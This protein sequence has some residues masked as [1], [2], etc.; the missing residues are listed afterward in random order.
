MCEDISKHPLYHYISTKAG[1]DPVKT[2]YLCAPE[3]AVRT[4]AGVAEFARQ[5]GWEQQAEDAGA[6][7]VAPVAPL[8]WAAEPDDLL[9]TLY[10]ETR[11]SFATCSGISIWGRSGSLWCWETMLYLV[12][13]HAGAD[14]AGR[15]LVRCPNVFAGTALVGGAPNNFAV[16]EQTSDHWLV[17][18]VGRNYNL[19]NQDIPTCL[20]M[21]GGEADATAKTTAHFAKALGATAE[22]ESTVGG[23]ACRSIQSKTTPAAEIRQFPGA[24]GAVPSLADLIMHQCFAHTI[25]WKNSPDGTLAPLQS[26]AE[27]YADARHVRR[28]VTVGAY[29][30]D[31]FIRLPKGRTAQEAQGLP[32][33]LTVHGRGEPAWMFMGKNGW[34]ELQDETGAFVLL[35]PDSPGNIWFLER[36]GAALCQM[37]AEAVAAFKLDA[38]RVYLTGFSN[39]G[40]ITREVGLRYPQPWAAIS[41]WNAPRCDTYPLQ[42]VDANIT[43]AQFS[44]EFIAVVRDFHASGWELPCYFIYGDR[45]GAAKAEENALLP[46]FL[47]ANR[48]AA[49]P[50]ATLRGAADYPASA[51]YTQGDRFV[52]AV[53]RGPAGKPGVC[54]TTMQ[55]MPHGSISDECRAVWDFLRHFRRRPG[56]T[57][58]QWE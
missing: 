19:K 25:R 31:Y 33:V 13:Y 23:F 10:N 28:S 41:P 57:A 21:F 15:A 22:T 44:R 49:T 32:L 8:G 1:C 40:M 4:A 7:L 27:F 9:Q 12:G 51:G 54:V 43:P 14:F 36:D 35:S 48:C 53:Y 45:D 20:W 58:V 2:I 50:A 18:Q 5:S 47:Q 17:K 24:F 30:Y 37:A 16:G 6:V 56:E 46:T 11:N 26:K 29:T 3:P 42:A 55:N 52:T 38:T 34:D 39:G